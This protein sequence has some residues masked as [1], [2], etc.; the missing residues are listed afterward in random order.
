MLTLPT[1]QAALVDAID[2]DA[3][4]EG[5]VTT[6]WIAAKNFHSF[7]ASV[8]V[9]DMA[10]NHTV[11]AKLEQATTSGGGSA[12][13]VSGAAITQLTKADSDDNQQAII[14][15][16]TEDLDVE[17]GFDYVR[18]S[19]TLAST[20][21]PFSGNTDFGGALYGFNPRHAPASDNDAS[22]VDE[23]VTV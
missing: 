10:S 1:E 11:D 5:A 12:K 17:N 22:T 20:A 8:Y 23:I 21:S 7:M 16:R 3:Y 14:N 13:D 6:A 9:G 4:G 15:L 19:I 18:L 2:P